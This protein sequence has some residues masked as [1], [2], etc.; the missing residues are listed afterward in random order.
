MSGDEIVSIIDALNRVR[1]EE[2][3]DIVTQALRLITNTMGGDEIVSIIRALNTVRAEERRDVVTQAL[4]LISDTMSGDEI[5]S[6]ID[7][8]N[9]VRAEE[10]PDIVTQAL[11]L[12]TNTM[13]GEQ[14]ASII[15]HLQM[16]SPVQRTPRVD[17]SVI[18][19]QADLLQQPNLNRYNRIRE[20]LGTPLEEP[21]P[22]LNQ[23][24]EAAAVPG[25]VAI[26]VHA[27]GRDQKTQAA[28][29]LLRTAQG[30]IEPEQ[31][32]LAVGS[33]TTYLET[34][35]DITAE[36][37]R[38][39]LKA[40]KGEPARNDFGPLLGDRSC[41]G[42][43]ISGEEAIGRFWIYADRYQDSNHAEHSGNEQA[44][45]KLGMIQALS[46]SYTG[47]EE[48]LCNEGKVQRLVV[49]VLQGRLP[50]VDIDRVG[51]VV[52]TAA[53]VNMFF[54]VQNHRDIDNFADL[55]AAAA[56]FCQQNPRVERGAFLV[57]IHAYA[58]QQ[59]I[60]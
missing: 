12:I 43:Q 48:R 41:G 14:R 27:N 55:M 3:P 57:A 49:N 23:R 42:Y 5:V 34:K 26:N 32:A 44:N 37:K 31:I 35:M 39:A 51:G 29:A 11:R 10:R 17:R 7:A 22:A 15:N 52:S 58:D 59:E 53:A 33:F 21:L 8:L 38:L 4:R 47:N 40:L 16:I 2:R 36:T 60:K 46:T 13:G 30:P 28:L 6:I 24:M 18:Q 50:G 25:N 54:N 56:L 1:A 9:R 45:A 19:L 20:L